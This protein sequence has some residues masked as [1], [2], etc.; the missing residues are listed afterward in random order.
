VDIFQPLATEAEYRHLRSSSTE[1]RPHTILRFEDEDGAELFAMGDF[2]NKDWVEATRRRGVVRTTCWVPGNFLAEGR[3]SV[4]V[5]ASTFDPTVN[6]V[7]E[8]DAVAFQIV[9]GE[10][11]RWR[12]RSRRSRSAGRRFR[13][14][15][16]RLGIFTYNTT[17]SNLILRARTHRGESH[18]PADQ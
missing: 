10:P 15:P 5:Q 17:S 3:V 13:G 2:N 7:E 9:K 8:R 12:T 1:G 11:W 16:H 14:T 6:D 4:M 18:A